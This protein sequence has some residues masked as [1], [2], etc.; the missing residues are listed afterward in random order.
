MDIQ[1][2]VCSSRRFNKIYLKNVM[3]RNPRDCVDTIRS[4]DKTSE[5]ALNIHQKIQTLESHGEF[6]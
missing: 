3:T 6:T 4:Y 1:C 2:D 5:A